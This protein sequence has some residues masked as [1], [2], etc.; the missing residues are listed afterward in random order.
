[1]KLKQALGAYALCALL[2]IPSRWSLPLLGAFLPP[3]APNHGPRSTA[4]TSPALALNIEYWT[5][6]WPHDPSPHSDSL[7]VDGPSNSAAL[8]VAM[9]AD[10]RARPR[11]KFNGMPVSTR[12]RASIRPWAYL[13]LIDDGVWSFLAARGDLRLV[14]SV[15]N[16]IQPAPLLIATPPPPPSLRMR[17]AV[18]V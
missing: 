9:G 3:W 13:C 10:P 6:R 5:R 1:M 17:Y 14:L 12:A 7:P 4:I 15:Q 11:Y 2:R 18:Y 8:P 16:L